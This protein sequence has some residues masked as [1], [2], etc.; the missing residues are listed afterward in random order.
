MET[1]T[2]HKKKNTNEY[3]QHDLIFIIRQKPEQANNKTKLLNSG[4]SNVKGIHIKSHVKMFAKVANARAKENKLL[5]LYLLVLHLHLVHFNPLTRVQTQ[6]W[7]FETYI[8][9]FKRNISSAK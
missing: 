1:V 6:K 2:L 5:K 8:I 3:E 4:I 7:E 9:K